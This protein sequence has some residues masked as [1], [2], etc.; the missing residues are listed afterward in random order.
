MNAFTKYSKTDDYTTPVE[1]LKIIDKFIPKD[2]LVV[3]G[4]WNEGDV[5]YYWEEQLGR[6]I[7]H[8]P[9]D[10]FE[11]TYPSD[12]IFVSN[13]PFSKINEILISLF[14]R[15]NQFALLLPIQKI[16]QLKVQ[17]I[18][19][20]H[21]EHLQMIVSDVYCGFIKDGQQTRCPSQYFCWF[22]YK[23]NLPRDLMWVG[24]N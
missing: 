24:E 4:F 20:P 7:W 5:Q 9:T 22:T 12:S 13:P 18:L 19:L 16:A 6:K 14:E 3:D 17:K 21:Q 15:G 11:T 8:Q 1:Y 10:F 2:K 23:F